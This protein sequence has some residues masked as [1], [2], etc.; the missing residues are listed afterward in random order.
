MA[1]NRIS[2]MSFATKNYEIPK[3][4]IIT[5]FTTKRRLL[6]LEPQNL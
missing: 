5:G 2:D 1:N 6:T 4:V 3:S